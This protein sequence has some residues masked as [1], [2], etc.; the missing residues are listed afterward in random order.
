MIFIRISGERER[1]RVR[2]PLVPRNEFCFTPTFLLARSLARSRFLC[3][4][5]IR[6]DCSDLVEEES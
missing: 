5:I 1:E 3:D 6:T 4:R 2:G